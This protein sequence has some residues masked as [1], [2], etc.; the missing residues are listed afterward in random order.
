MTYAELAEGVNRCGNLLKSMRIARSDRVLMIVKDCPEFFYLFWGAIK[1][2]IIPAP[3]NTLL[4]TDDYRHM[5]ED[6]EC[7]VVVYSSEFE[8]EVEPAIAQASHKP[9]PITISGD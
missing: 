7:A 1:A 2:G 4:R 9:F 6:S 3:V 8:S 5:I